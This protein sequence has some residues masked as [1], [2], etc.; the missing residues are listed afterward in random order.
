MKTYRPYCID[1]PLLLPP[2][3][4]EWLPEDHLAYF[5]SDLIDQLDLTPILREY[6]DETRGYPPY[7]PVMMVK[8]LV[9]AYAT[10][11]YSSRQIARRLVED[12][13]FRVLGAGNFP[14]FRT[15]A[16]FRKRHLK[17]LGELFVQVLKLCEAAGLVK[18]GEIVLDGSKIL[19]NAS[20]HKAMSYERM[21]AKEAQLRAEVAELLARAAAI[22]AQED[23]AYGPDCRG[24]ELPEELAFRQKRLRKIQE[25]KAALEARYRQA[26]DGRET[27]GKPTD[28]PAGG[29]SPPPP[30]PATEAKHSESPE[31]AAGSTSTAASGVP[32]KA[33]INFTDPDSRIM[34]G[35][36][37]SWVQAYNVQIAVD[38]A[39]QVIVH[40][41]VTAQP[42]DAP[43][44]IPMIQGVRARM[45]ADP[46][47]CLADA[48]FFSEENVAFLLEQGIEPFIAAD[49]Q[50]HGHVPPPPPKGRIPKHLSARERMRRK[51]A[52]RR[53]R[54][55][56]GKRKAVV[57]PVW[58]Q[59]KQ[60][61]GFRRFSLRGQV[62]C[63]REF[64]LVAAAHD[65]LKL[66]R[67][68]RQV[69]TAFMARLRQKH[70]GFG[71]AM[72]APVGP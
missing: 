60:A 32:P 31:P 52:T 69:V 18:L 68:G 41:A 70:G 21:V 36:G 33:Q 56:Y 30:A 72:P 2:D 17:A 9:Y 64:Q 39:Y 51:L 25:A 15:I 8:V 61:R 35:P 43:H 23:A 6:E 49:K 7:H 57:E 29:A 53:G 48:G 12:I 66:F 63:E 1:Q 54:R 24:D 46:C 10:G 4:R 16:A 62:N 58:G 42:A 71:V 3:L 40:T 26:T 65:A 44:L 67:Y 19:A 37:K 11:V 34:R 20:K 45:G 27:T 55:I 5:I 38:S 14:D 59:I 22:D 28:P 47:R 50:R 13:A